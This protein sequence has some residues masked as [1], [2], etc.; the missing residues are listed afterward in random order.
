ME[1]TGAMGRDVGIRG[2]YTVLVPAALRTRP[3]LDS[4]KTELLRVGETVLVHEGF[5]LSG[6]KLR[7]RISRGWVSF[8]S[9]GGDPILQ[10]LSWFER[11][12][13]SV[14]ALV[15]KSP[16]IGQPTGERKSAPPLTIS[17]PVN[18]SYKVPLGCELLAECDRCVPPG[19]CR[20][21]ISTPGGKHEHLL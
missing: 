16:R 13:E 15:E 14:L 8:E 4:P 12:R 17:N 5:R 11:T 1:A 10:H 3:E 19:F 20:L 21:L 9:G 18:G 2:L 7:A 6:G